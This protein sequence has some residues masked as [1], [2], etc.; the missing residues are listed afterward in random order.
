MPNAPWALTDDFLELHKIDFV[1]HDE[2]PYGGSDCDDLYAHIK[3]RGMFVATDRTEGM[4]FTLSVVK[5]YS[6]LFEFLFA[7]QVFQRRISLLALSKTMICMFAEIWHVA[8]RR[9][10]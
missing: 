10:S 2:I 6:D 7:L 9:K 8:I 1:A 3:Q 4:R 5:D